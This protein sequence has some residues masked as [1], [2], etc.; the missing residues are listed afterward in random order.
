[1]KPAPPPAAA[2]TV[3]GPALAAATAYA[4]WLAGPAVE[5]GLLGPREADRV[6]ERHLLN[7]AALAGELARV[8]P[9]DAATGRRRRV[10]D[11]GSGAGLPGIVVALLRPDLEVVLLEPLL[12]RAT[13][14]DEVVAALALPA[15]TVVRARA[16][17]AAR[18]G[19]FDVVVARAVAPLGRLAAWALPLLRP[20]GELLALKGERAAAEVAA[21]SSSVRRL[22][23]QV[24]DVVPVTVAG[25]ETA[26]VAV[27]R[28]LD[29]PAAAGRMT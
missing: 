8:L 10:C 1:M 29:L 18:Y 20:G 26:V 4:G 13:F 22:G 2:E 14:L 16:E 11:L 24:R 21:A 7:S 12:R 25:Q 27:V 15:T 23:A 19:P 28:P 17:D 6:W 9:P 3:F 5:R